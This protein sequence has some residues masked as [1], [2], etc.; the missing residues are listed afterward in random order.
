MLSR[1][2]L[3]L[4]LIMLSCATMESPSSVSSEHA[5]K[6]Y[7]HG[8]TSTVVYNPNG[9]SEIVRMRREDAFKK[10][11]EFCGSKNYEIVSERKID[12]KDARDPENSVATVA[13]DELSRIE[14][15]CL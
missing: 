13:A 9:L 14:F 2:V 3:G 5:P 7:N 12:P 4:S 8:K 11:F 6:N 10:M 1:S 15:K